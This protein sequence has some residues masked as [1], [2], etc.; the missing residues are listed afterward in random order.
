MLNVG[1]TP[2]RLLPVKWCAENLERFGAER[3]VYDVLTAKPVPLV[4]KKA[5]GSGAMVTDPEMT[6]RVV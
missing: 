5:A 6:R 2:F 1:D 4:N 3:I